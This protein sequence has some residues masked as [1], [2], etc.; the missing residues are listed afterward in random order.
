MKRMLLAV[1]LLLAVNLRA[2]VTGSLVS[3][4][5][6]PVAG[7]RVE[8]FEAIPVGHVLVPREI[9]FTPEGAS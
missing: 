1:F 2:D 5:G 6:K 9:R 7:A 8:L 4:E 3:S